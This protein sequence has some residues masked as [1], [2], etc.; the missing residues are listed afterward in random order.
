MT[1]KFKVNDIIEDKYSIEEVIGF[2]DDVY[3]LKRIES[4]SWVTDD[5]PLITSINI[6]FGDRYFTMNKKYLWNKQMKEIVSEEDN[7]SLDTQIETK[8]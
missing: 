6:I 1:P 7:S 3:T 8:E 5:Q 2:K 4:K